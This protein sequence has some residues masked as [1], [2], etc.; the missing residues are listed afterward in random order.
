MVF[1]DHTHL[2]FFG[3][4]FGNERKI[5]PLAYNFIRI[6]LFPSLKNADDL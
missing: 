3:G 1:P 6:V 4:N 5:I 2:L